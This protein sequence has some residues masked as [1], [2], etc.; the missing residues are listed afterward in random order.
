MKSRLIGSDLDGVIAINQ[1]NKAYYRPYRL[2]QYYSKCIPTHFRD[3]YFDVIITGRRIHFKKIT[4]QWLADNQIAYGTLVMFPNKVKK[5]NKTL[6]EFKEEHINELSI[7]QFY[8]DDKRI[9]K[10][11]KISCPNT[12]IN[13]VNLIDCREEDKKMEEKRFENQVKHKN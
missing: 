2:Y 13:L 10:Y 7:T 9:A 5:S 1:L 11:L 3:M 6:A 4:L 8:E 12:E